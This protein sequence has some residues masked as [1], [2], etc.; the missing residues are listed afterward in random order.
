MVSSNS[1]QI[2]SAAPDFALETLAGQSIRLSDFR[3]KPVLLT[4]GASWCPDCQ[5]EAH[6]LQ[7]LHKRR[8]NLVVLMVDTKEERAL[9][10]AYADEFG[11]TFPVALDTNGAV[12]EIYR[13]SALP[14][15]FLIDKNGVIQACLIESVTESSL[16]A[17][18]RTLGLRP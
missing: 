5:R 9:V 1:L 10:Q 17:L 3:G 8:R 15:E 12:A 18:L 13:V 16:A 7:R 14:T 4:L 11:L 2:G 6:L